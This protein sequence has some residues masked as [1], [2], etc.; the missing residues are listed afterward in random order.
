MNL[1]KIDTTANKCGQE[2]ACRLFLPKVPPVDGPNFK[3]LLSQLIAK[4]DL[5]NILQKNHLPM[6]TFTDTL[7]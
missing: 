1:P 4:V 2:F 3:T 5:L 6:N 7:R